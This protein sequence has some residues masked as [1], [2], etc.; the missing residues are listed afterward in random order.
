MKETIYFSQLKAILTLALMLC[1]IGA[2]SQE[3]WESQYVKIQPNGKLYYIPDEQG[4]VIPDFSRVGYHQNTKPIPK[5]K[6]VITLSATGDND[7]QKIQEAIDELA[8]RPA[9]KDGIRGAILLKKG[10]Y[11]IPGSLRISTSGIV[12]RG[13]GNETKLIAT[14]KG[15]RKTIVA[16]GTGKAIEIPNTR[17]KISDVY[18]P[19]G[20]KSFRLGSVAGLKVGDLI[21]VFRPGTDNWINDLKMDQIAPGNNTV[22]WTG[23]AYNFDFE[24]VIMAIKDNTV[25]LDNPIVLAMETKYGGGEIYKYTFDGR[26][27]EVGIED[28]VLESE[29]ESEID[30]DHGWDAIS[31]NRIADSWVS[32]VTSMYF[33]YSCVNLGN[34]SKQITVKDSKCLA[35]KSQIIGGRRYSFNNDGQLNLFM[36]CFASE[37]RHDYVTGAKV[38]GPNVFFNCTSVNAQADNGPHHRL[39]VGT[40]FDNLT[41]DGEINIQDRGNWGTGHGWA[42]I[43]QVIWNSTAAKAAIQ[44]PYVG[45]KNYAIGF[46]A[47]K[48]EGRL[49]GRPVGIWEGQNKKNLNPSSLYLKQVEDTKT[50]KL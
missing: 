17:T 12:L 40:L 18:V 26:I 29:F 32:G 9:N 24:R 27:T 23:A 5:V 8:K 48:Y 49:T 19:V 50:K 47:Q 21:M 10:T 4:N 44:N 35:P 37:G 20:A 2:F 13:E 31:F 33:G 1:F 42:G 6:T 43:N 11:K 25:Y 36:N 38:R 16:S 46:T 3:K 7:Q 30:E 45:G 15:Q 22:Q 28:L 41:T 14:G 34:E 39:A